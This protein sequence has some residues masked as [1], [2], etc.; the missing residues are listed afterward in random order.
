MDVLFTKAQALRVGELTHP[1]HSGDAG[2]AVSALP[3]QKVILA[4]N[5]A[6][7]DFL[8]MGRFLVIGGFVAAAVQT[9][10]VR[11]LFSPVAST[12]LFSI[13]M[14][15]IMAIVLNLCSEADAFV[16]ASFRWTLV[17]DSAQLAFMVLGPMLD[18]KLLLMYLGLFRKRFIAALAGMTFV[19]VLVAMLL[20]HLVWK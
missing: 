6:A 5:H 8:D 17:P 1:V 20:M 3:R 7:H 15:M 14:M 12:P 10:A 2:C 16:A 11:H 4:I 18:I 13:L 19:W 9:L